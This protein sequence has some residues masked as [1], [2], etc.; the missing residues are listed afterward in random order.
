[1]ALFVVFVVLVL[2]FVVVGVAVFEH[3]V[4]EFCEFVGGGGDGFGGAESSAHAAVVC[5]ECAFT[6]M[7]A[8]GGDAQ[9]FCG[10]ALYVSASSFDD[11]SSRNAVIGA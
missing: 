10:A 3:P 8:L 11:F 9:G 5:A 1:M 6:S 2:S 7:Q 4:N